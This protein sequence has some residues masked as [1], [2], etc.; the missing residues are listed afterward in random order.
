MENTNLINSTGEASKMSR[1]EW[2]TECHRLFELNEL[3]CSDSLAEK[4]YLLTERMLEVNKTMNLTAIKDEKA[5]ILRHY[6]DSLKIS[7]HI[8]EGASVIDVGCGAGFPSLPLALARPDLKIVALDGTAKRIRYVAETAEMLG[9]TNLTA[10]AGR[11]EEY[12]MMPEYREKFD[13]VTARAVAAL[14][15]L[16]ELCVPFARL[17][18]QMIA[19]K[20]QQAEEELGAA[21][22]CIK[23]CGGVVV[24]KLPCSLTADGV[25]IEE[26]KLIFIEK[27]SHTPRI[28]PRHFSKISKKPL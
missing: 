7:A 12:A 20:S 14:P 19:M 15:V 27:R 23:L 26:R 24:D 2:P 3:P 4:L 1:E 21:Q 22:N 25:E 16:C 28:Y 9:A 10:I 8:P 6:V 13:V 17:G 18:G 11:A 5:V